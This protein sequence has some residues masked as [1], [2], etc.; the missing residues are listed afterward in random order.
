M[1][2]ISRKFGRADGLH[3]SEKA[4]WEMKMY[5]VA[6]VGF[7]VIVMRWGAMEKTLYLASIIHNIFR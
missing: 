2:E 6:A 7:W 4:R 1:E 5:A 3:N